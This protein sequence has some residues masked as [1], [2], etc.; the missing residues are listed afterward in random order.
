MKQ[1]VEA[2]HVKMLEAAGAR[3]V[4]VDFTLEK[5]ELEA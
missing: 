4:P 2:S 5:E 1:Y 3:P